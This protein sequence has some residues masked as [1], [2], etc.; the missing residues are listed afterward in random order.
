MS[1]HFSILLAGF[2]IFCAG[3][4]FLAYAF[5]LNNLQKSKLS[6]SFCGVLLFGLAS[7]QL[8]HYLSLTSSFDALSNRYYLSWLLL[9]PACFYFFSRFVLFPD[10]KFK[11]IHSVHALPF[12]VGLFCPEKMIPPVAFLI[13]TSYCF[14]VTHLVLKLRSQTKRFA[15]EMFFFGMFAVMAVVALV[16]GLMI[17]YIDST[18]FYLTYSTAIGIAILLVTFT[19]IVFPDVLTDIQ[20]IAG[21]VYANSKLKGVDID[22]KKGLLAA[23]TEEESVYQ[24]EKLSLGMVADMMDLSAHQLSELVNTQ[25]GM[26]FS[27]YIRMKRIEQAKKI[28]INEP[29]ISV[30]AVSIM[31]GFQSQSNF[32]S[33]FKE[34]TSMSPGKFRKG[35]Q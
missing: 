12:V 28:L 18:V 20:M 29:D 26:N 4:L 14:W 27:K 34:A 11:A 10:T 5:F 15:M 1:V 17:P 32:Y 35:S 33:A 31:T 2:T 3:L 21:T 6:I 9:V 8:G 13:G 25:Y 23:L 30:L 7:L 24:N 22:A 16:M 19:I